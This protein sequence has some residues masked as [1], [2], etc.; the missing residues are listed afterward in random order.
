MNQELSSCTERRPSS[1]KRTRKTG[2]YKTAE[3]LDTKICGKRQEE[4]VK[5]IRTEQRIY[6]SDI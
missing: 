1:R 2:K 6:L 4:E 3:R 5:E